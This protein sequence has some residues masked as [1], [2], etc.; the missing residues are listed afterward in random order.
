MKKML[1]DANQE[2]EVRV[3][4]VESK[5]LLDFESESLKNERVKG[6]IYLAKIIELNHL[7]RQ[8]LLIMEQKN[9]VFWPIMKFILTIL[10]YQQLTKKTS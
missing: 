4:I 1:I 8:L 9:M 7:C 3:A 6:N 10:K 5:D 2:N